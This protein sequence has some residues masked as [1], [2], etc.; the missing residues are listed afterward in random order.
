MKVGGID[1]GVSGTVSAVLIGK[2]PR[3]FEDY[4]MLISENVSAVGIDAPLSFPEKGPFRECER[5]LLGMGIRL[6]PSGA[7]FFRKV[8]ERGIEIAMEF[9]A[10][11]VEVYEVYPYATRVILDIAP[12]VKKKSRSGLDRIMASLSRYVELEDSVDSHDAVDAV[13]SALTVML[14]K[15][16]MGR[17]IDGRDGSILIPEVKKIG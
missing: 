7:E 12:Y 9:R 13:I 15:N 2:R 17:L 14:Y 6:F 5:K 16:G 3:V 1:V 10:A 11:G 8:V 4:R